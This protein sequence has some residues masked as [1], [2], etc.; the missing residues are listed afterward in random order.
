[1]KSISP[2][3]CN[4]IKTKKDVR[5]RHIMWKHIKSRKCTREKKSTIN[6]ISL[7]ILYFQYDGNAKKYKSPTI[8]SNAVA[9][10]LAIVRSIIKVLNK[11]RLFKIWFLYP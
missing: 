11:L 1:M 3:K 4:R 6:Y 7:Q 5:F 9:D 10:H 8:S 2:D